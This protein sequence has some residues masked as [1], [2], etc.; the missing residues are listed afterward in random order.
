MRLIFHGPPGVGKGTQAGRISLEEN[1]NHISSGDL[2][3]V[4]VDAK[5]E[6]GLKAKKYIENG[7]LVPD[8]LIVNIV[9]DK[10]NSAECER[11]FILDGF[12]R[13]L[14]QA[15]VL[16]STLEKVGKKLDR[17]FSFT[18]SEEVII[19]RISG[20]R[21]CKSCGAH[22]HEIFSSPLKKNICDKC[23]SELFQR[24]DDYPETIKVRLKVYK[25]QTETLIDYYNKK[26]ILVEIDCNGEK[27]EIQEN[28]LAGLQAMSEGK[29]DME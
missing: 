26:G 6:V 25:E 14:S 16:D 15:R 1:I 8:E 10:I 20:R 17:V 21:I 24:K 9:G 3:R 2:L 22:Y 29:R 27:K 4:A 19:T 5:T 7:L 23:G 11:G 12:P 18:A 13:N 28:I